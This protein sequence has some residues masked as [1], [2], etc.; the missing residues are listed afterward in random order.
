MKLRNL[1]ILIFSLSLFSIHSSE[2]VRFQRI[3][4]RYTEKPSMNTT[5]QF[6]IFYPIIFPLRY[7]RFVHPFKIATQPTL[8]RLTKD[9][10]KNHRWIQH[11]NFITRMRLLTSII[12]IF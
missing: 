8:K 1:Y 12:F 6:H 7:A 5:S 10:S 4:Q 2:S 9:P 11:R 3:H